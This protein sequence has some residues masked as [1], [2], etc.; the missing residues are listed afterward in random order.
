MLDK[1]NMILGGW[2][3]R[4]YINKL[5]GGKD[6]WESYTAVGLI[7]IAAAQAGFVSACGQ[8][9]LTAEQCATGAV[10]FT[11]L[12]EVMVIFGVRRGGKK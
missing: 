5:L 3:L 1:V 10:W 4:P 6:F 12:G 9:F 11:R 2:V 7:I 8:N